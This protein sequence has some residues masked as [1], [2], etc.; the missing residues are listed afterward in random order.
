MSPE[1]VQTQVS[2]AAPKCPPKVSAY[3]AVTL[4]LRGLG[5]LRLALIPGIHSPTVH[6]S[7]AEIEMRQPNSALT[8]KLGP[9]RPQKVHAVTGVFFR[10]LGL[11]TTGL[12]TSIGSFNV[13][14]NTSLNCSAMVSHWYVGSVARS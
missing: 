1:K 9:K 13:S 8:K 11:R 14:S 12:S 5:G 4:R 3:I 6:Y 2:Q 7:R 10:R